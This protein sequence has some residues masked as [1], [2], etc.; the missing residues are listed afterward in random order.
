MITDNPEKG[1]KYISVNN[2]VLMC[3]ECAT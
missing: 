2:A 1:V 3:E